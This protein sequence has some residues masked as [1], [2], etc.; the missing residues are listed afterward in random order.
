MAEAFRTAAVR[1]PVGK[2]G[3]RLSTTHPADLAAHVLRTIVDRSSIEPAAIDDVILGFVSQV[4]AQAYNIA[5]TAV[6]SAGF[7]ETVPATTVERQCGSSQQALHFAA[8]AVRS[9][10]QDLVIAGGVEVMSLV[11]LGSSGRLGD[12]AGM[13]LPRSGIGWM[14][15]YGDEVISQFRGAEL[16]AA[17][18]DIDR[19]EMEQLAVESHRRALCATTRGFFTEEIATW[20]D[21]FVDE[22]PLPDT[23]LKKLSALKPIKDCATLTAGLASQISDGAAASLVASESAISS[24]GLTP[25]ARVRATAVVGCDPITM[26]SGPI[27]ATE[28]ALQKSGL[29]IDDIELFEVNEAFAPVVLARQRATGASLERTNVLLRDRTGPPTW[30]FGSENHDDVDTPHATDSKHIWPTDDVR[31][32]WHGQCDDSRIGLI[33]DRDTHSRHEDPW[34]SLSGRMLAAQISESSLGSANRRHVVA[35]SVRI[36]Q[37]RQ[38]RRN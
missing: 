24:Y 16:I 31:R 20:Q 5:R 1:T 18:W 14:Q 36:I 21:V 27:P 9:G 25:L 30:G 12:E 33:P 34:L 7:P 13:G 8:Q 6:L 38:C 28:R 37:S 23:T 32:R 2:R 3:G 26:L 29:E 17:K 10:D 15:R 19:E 22:G 11:P 35:G 4:G